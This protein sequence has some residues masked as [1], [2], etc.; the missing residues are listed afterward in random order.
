[1]APNESKA[2]KMVKGVKGIKK[3][4]KKEQI[5]DIMGK[6]FTAISKSKKEI[7]FKGIKKHSIADCVV[8]ITAKEKLM[9]TKKEKES[10]GNFFS[11]IY[12]IK[13]PII[14]KVMKCSQQDK[15]NFTKA[16]L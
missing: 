16:N 2:T 13:L 12:F 5:A 11:K 1:M 15:V 4:A 9:A 10:K 3:T 8:V 14:H 7:I 6:T